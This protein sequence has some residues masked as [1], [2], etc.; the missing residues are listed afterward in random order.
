MA[1]VHGDD[2]VTQAYKQSV[3]AAMGMI[4]DYAA[5]Y[6]QREGGGPP[7]TFKSDSLIWASV[8]H[9]TSRDGDPQLHIHSVLASVTVDEHGKFHSLTNDEMIKAGAKAAGWQIFQFKL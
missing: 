1:L 2:R 4:Q 6:R 8:Q 9:E 3:E 7:E 5:Q